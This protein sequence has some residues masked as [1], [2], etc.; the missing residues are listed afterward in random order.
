[1]KVYEKPVILTNEELA[2]GVYAG[3]GNCYTTTARIVQLPESTHGYIIQI[4]ATHNSGGHHSTN[5]HVEVTFNQ[6]VT[7]V[8]SEASQCWGSGSTKL[9]LEYAT[10]NGAPYH[11]NASEYIGLGNL[12][13]TAEAGL[14]ITGCR[15]VY[16]DEDCEQH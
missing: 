3:S 10:K 2:E 11:N 1:M 7:Y 16:C 14:A 5:R 9:T 13:V 12:E 4:D 6:V 15:C 8:S